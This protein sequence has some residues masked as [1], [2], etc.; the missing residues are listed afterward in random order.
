MTNANAESCSVLETFFYDNLQNLMD[1]VE[2]E[3]P[4]LYAVF[5]GVFAIDLNDTK[6][7]HKFIC[8][9]VGK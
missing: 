1:K 9:L 5:K 7:V 2:I 4:S 6:Q 8:K 3:Y